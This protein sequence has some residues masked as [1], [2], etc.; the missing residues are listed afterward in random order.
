[1]FNSLSCGILSCD[2]NGCDHYNPRHD[3][4]FRIPEGPIL[5]SEGKIELSLV[6]PCMDH[7]SS[8]MGEVKGKSPLLYVSVFNKMVSV[9]SERC[10]NNHSIFYL[11]KIQF[12]IADHELDVLM[13][14]FIL[15]STQQLAQQ[16]LTI[17]VMQIVVHFLHFFS[18]CIAT[19]LNIPDTFLVV[20]YIDLKAQDWQVFFFVCYFLQSCLMV[21]FVLIL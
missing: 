7:S 12:V 1:M 13:A 16:Y 5:P 21:R 17:L 15:N 3:V 18:V 6:W 14:K 10:G 19:L 8:Q 9:D 4:G 2:T 11:L 20:N